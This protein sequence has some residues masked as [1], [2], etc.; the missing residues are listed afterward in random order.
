MTF[1]IPFLT[2]FGV[3]ADP[4]APQVTIKTVKVVDGLRPVAL[5]AAPGGARVALSLEDGTVRIIDAKTRVTLRKLAN[6]KEAANAIAWSLDGAF[7][8]TGDET[9]RVWVE[10]A[11]SGAKVREYR[12]HTR[13]VQKVSFN[14]LGNTLIST[15]KDDS[16]R[17]YD[18]TSP[19][20]KAIGTIVGNGLN[21][22]G[23]TFSPRSTYTF[24]V[25]LLSGGIRLYDAKTRKIVKIVPDNG[26]QGIFDVSFSPNGKFCVAA[27][28]DGYATL[29]DPLKPAKIGKLK[30]HTDWVV[31]AAISPNGKLVATSSTDGSVRVWDT[32]TLTKIAQVDDENSVGSPL[33]FTGDGSTLVTVNSAGA[34][35]FHSVTPAQAAEADAAVKSKSKSKRKGRKSSRR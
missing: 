11:G 33:A 14:S 20:K 32:K 2:L 3:S 17:I 29:W 22:F 30:G 16:V 24:G 4:V 6:H 21:V 8:A 1:L 35:Q 13:G 25:G 5:A 12:D 23:A 31:Y 19:K 7:V 18:L 10:N 9:G 26:G 27:G 28:R 15:G 34:V